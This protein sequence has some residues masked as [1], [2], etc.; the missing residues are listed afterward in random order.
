MAPI[1]TPVPPIPYCGPLLIGA[2]LAWLL[3]GVFLAQLIRYSQRTGPTDQIYIKALVAVVALT[4]LLQIIFVTH[5]V[6]WALV[7]GFVNPMNFVKQSITAP[8]TLILNGFESLLFQVFFA[9][10]I[11]A[12][13][14]KA[15]TVIPLSILIISLSIVQFGASM[16][17]AIDFIAVGLDSHALQA[18]YQM[19]MYLYLATSM[20]ADVIITISVIAFLQ[21]YKMNTHYTPTKGLLSTLIVNTIETGFIVTA[22][23]GVNLIVCLTTQGLIGAAFQYVIGGVYAVALM[24]TLNRRETHRQSLD[25]TND[26]IPNSNAFD[27]SVLD[28]SPYEKSSTE[29][30]DSFR[31]TVTTSERRMSLQ[32][33]DMVN[34]TRKHETHLDLG[35]V[36]TDETLEEGGKGVQPQ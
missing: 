5:K 29:G 23:S 10:R 9:W 25:L 13:T 27:L 26:P 28:A 1:D 6:W 18:K 19:P 15:R 11:F 7:L 4:Q 3:A 35:S 31:R 14:G 21:R 22:F 36:S 12:L 17:V 32:R 2:L 24:A 20:V 33:P 8:A 30:G 34:V 16:G